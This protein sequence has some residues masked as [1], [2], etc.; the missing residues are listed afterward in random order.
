LAC[1]PRVQGVP[2]SDSRS[3]G[4][5]R[6]GDGLAE[7]MTSG[8]RWSAKVAEAV[9]GWRCRTS[10][11]QLGRVRC[12]GRRGNGLVELGRAGLASWAAGAMLGCKA[13]LV[14][15]RPASGWQA[16]RASCCAGL[17]RS[18]L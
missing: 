9:L 16:A 6:V 12:A 7:G 15:W 11:G 14:G 4:D 13:A 1:G 8:S 10:L 18:G 17:L 2:K 5:V 3:G